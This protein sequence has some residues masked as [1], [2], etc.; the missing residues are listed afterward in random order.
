MV[1]FCSVDQPKTKNI[2]FLTSSNKKSLGLCFHEILITE[3]RY[4]HT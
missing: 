1:I 4:V 2:P 3:A